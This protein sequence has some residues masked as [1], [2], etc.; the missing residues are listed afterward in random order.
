MN[1]NFAE[2]FKSLR[3]EKG[4]TQE[5]IADI[6]G[7]SSQSI[8]RWE[9]CICY[10][11][12]EMLPSI[13][14]YF[15]VT[16]DHLLSNDV[17]SKEKERGLFWKK[18]DQLSYSTTETIDFVNEYCKKYPEDDSYAFQLICAIKDYAFRNEKRAEECMPL[19]LKNVQRLL[20]TQYRYETIRIMITL[21]AEDELEKWLDMTPYKS[22]FSRR[23]CL[24]ERA[25]NCESANPSYIQQGLER[26]ETFAAQLDSRCPDSLGA[27]R[28]AKHQESVL[29]AVRAFGGDAVPDGWKFFYAYKELVLSAC[30]FGCGETETGWQHFD[31]AIKMCKDA[32]SIED[33][34]LDIG[35]EFFSNL[36]VNKI[37]NYAI[38]EDGNK[39]KLFDVVNY[40]FS[41]MDD[42]YY[43]LT[44]PQ[45][46]WFNSV[47]KTDKFQAAV[48]WAKEAYH[49]LNEEE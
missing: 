2:N 41:D 20:E 35:G 18:L 24:V 44:A 11:D 31:S 34:W 49:Q 25:Y 8:S 1:L 43:L 46:A 12:I 37:W 47:R 27:R 6:L 38:D 14:N 36:K 23:A 42:I 10:P 33:E 13:A 19:L 9:L 39:H 15:G 17:L 45:W 4:I 32:L 5:K 29:K 3:K 22:D 16:V 26:F 30:L 21:C 40:S 7:V 28:K 48:T